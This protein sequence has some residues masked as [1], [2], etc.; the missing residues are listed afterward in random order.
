M[1]RLCLSSKTLNN[2]ALKQWFSAT[3]VIVFLQ[4]CNWFQI[5]AERSNT[6]QTVE[7]SACISTVNH[8]G[9]AWFW[10]VGHIYPW[11]ISGRG[12]GSSALVRLTTLTAPP[13]TSPEPPPPSA[14]DA[15]QHSSPWT[16]PSAAHSKSPRASEHTFRPVFCHTRDIQHSTFL[17]KQA[18]TKRPAVVL[19][20]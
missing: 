3:S 8:E 17:W 2:A 4:W 1:S 9:H 15:H 6:K 20:K 7:N 16:T 14:M 11:E 19:N 5:K 18:A 10:A 12:R 13:G